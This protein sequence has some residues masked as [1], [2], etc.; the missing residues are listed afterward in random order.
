MM[1]LSWVTLIFI[2]IFSAGC[3]CAPDTVAAG[4]QPLRE[5]P[6]PTPDVDYLKVHVI[7]ARPLTKGEKKNL[8]STLPLAVRH[9][10]EEA[11]SLQVL[12][13]SSD[14]KAGIGWYP[15]LK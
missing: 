2:A 10:L 8:D 3:N 9:I 12:G 15:D 4:P 7:K 1:R 14:D 5:T 6:T 11:E 13:L